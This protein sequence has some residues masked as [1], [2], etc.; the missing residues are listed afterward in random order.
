VPAQSLYLMNSPYVMKMAEFAAQRLLTERPKSE[1]HR[2]KLAYERIF[3]RPP[4]EAE[5]E[6]AL[7]FVKSKPDAEQAWAAL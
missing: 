7:K 1:P 5:I 6:A 2:V 4:T 3:N